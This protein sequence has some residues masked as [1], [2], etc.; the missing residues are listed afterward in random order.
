ME[1]VTSCLVYSLTV[2]HKERRM[3][4]GTSWEMILSGES[5]VRTMNC[6]WLDR[7]LCCMA[8]PWWSTT[9]SLVLG[10]WDSYLLN[11][12]R[13]TCQCYMV[14]AEVMARLLV[15]C[16]HGMHLTVLRGKSFLSG[17]YGLF[18]NTW[19]DAFP[20]QY[21]LKISIPC[22]ILLFFRNTLILPAFSGPVKLCGSLLRWWTDKQLSVGRWRAE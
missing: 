11:E 21:F 10:A 19:C 13:L 18:L 20:N 3:I 14:P 2:I 15:D 7:W 6:L 1:Q 9:V 8:W 5:H 22:W 4:L 12:C 16:N 17:E